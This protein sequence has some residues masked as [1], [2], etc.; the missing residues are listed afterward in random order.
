[1]LLP[2]IGLLAPI[3][4]LLLLRQFHRLYWVEDKQLCSNS[5]NERK[6]N[7]HDEK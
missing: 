2:T 1:M 4:L 3:M 6:S 7:E 5:S